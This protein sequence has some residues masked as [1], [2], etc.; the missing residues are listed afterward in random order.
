MRF[1]SIFGK[2]TLLITIIF[3]LLFCY[4]AQHL[5]VNLSRSMPRGVYW[6]SHSKPK[7][8]DWVAVCLPKELAQLALSRHYLHAGL[9]PNQIEPLLKKVVAVAPT[10]I[11]LSNDFIHI[12]QIK[13]PHSATLSFDQLHQ[14]LTAIARGTIYLTGSQIWLYGIDSPR[15]W[16]SRYFGAINSENIAGVAMP[17]LIFKG[18]KHHE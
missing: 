1:R 6:L 3:L 14:P 15:S 18:S 5:R 9:C 7:V 16:D 13:L 10:Q 17:L 8:G 4:C 12:Q 2:Y 11:V